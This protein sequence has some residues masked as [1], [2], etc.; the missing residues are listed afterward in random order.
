ML[1]VPAL[2]MNDPIATTNQGSSGCALVALDG[3][4][5][6]LERTH[7]AAQA[8]GASP[9]SRSSRCFATC[10]PSRCT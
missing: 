7:L 8:R 3:R 10:T 2:P 1:H 4:H 5:L 9:G 6:P